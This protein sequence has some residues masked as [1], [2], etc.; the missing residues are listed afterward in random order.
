MPL[1]PCK[2]CNK[3]ISDSASICPNCGVS[4]PCHKTGSLTISRKAAF[5]GSL[6][7]AQISVDGGVSAEIKNGASVTLDLPAGER[8]ISISIGNKCQDFCVDVTEGDKA[9]YEFSLS[10]WGKLLL[11]PM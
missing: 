7:S 11:N 3:E 5:S 6:V 1:K 8:N 4:S 9:Q 10:M 2:E